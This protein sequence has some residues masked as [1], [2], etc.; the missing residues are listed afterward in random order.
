MRVVNRR[1]LSRGSAEII[2]GVLD[3]REPVEV[4]TRGRGSVV[5]SPKV[6]SLY[7]Q[8]VTQGL[9]QP[10]NGENFADLPRLEGYPNGY[11]RTVQDVLADMA[12]DH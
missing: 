3:T 2:D 6:E 9:V 8:W 1:E 12:S 5:I 4:V 7:D 10:G 11:P